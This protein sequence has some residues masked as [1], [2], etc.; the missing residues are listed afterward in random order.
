M[1]AIR[2]LRRLREHQAWANA[3]LLDA[4]RGLTPEQFE[5]TFP[6]GQGSVLKTLTHLYGA[7]SVWLEALEGQQDPV[8]PFDIRF[9]TLAD[10]ETAWQTLDRRWAVYFDRLSD[11]DLDAPVAKRSSSSGAGRV[12]VT[13]TSDV[14]LHLATHA[15]YTAA[16]LKNMLRHLGV[17]PLPDVMLITL[18]RAAGQPPTGR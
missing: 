6:I 3:R 14:L 4:A 13:S 16:Q 1:E 10:L 7:E 18:A 9:A 11:A 8:S 2:L 17:S 15:Q 12:F 5:R